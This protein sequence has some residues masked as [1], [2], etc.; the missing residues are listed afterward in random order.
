MTEVPQIRFNAG[1]SFDG[2]IFNLIQYKAAKF[3]IISSSYQYGSERIINLLDIN[4][5]NGVSY[6]NSAGK[7]WKIDKYNVINISFR[8]TEFLNKNYSFQF[9]VFNLT[10]EKLFDNYEDVVYISNSANDF[11]PEKVL[12]KP[13]RYFEG[14]FNI[15]F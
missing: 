1:L 12:P 8:T 15:T 14:K 10:D 13:G 4:P 3:Y 9:S 2:S 7:R 5:E 11:S 6:S